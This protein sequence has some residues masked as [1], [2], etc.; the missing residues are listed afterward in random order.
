LL[1]PCQGKPSEKKTRG[2]GKRIY[3]CVPSYALKLLHLNLTKENPVKKT[4][5]KEKEY[6]QYNHFT[7]PH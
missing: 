1:K 5:V 7:P 2:E 3:S 4:L 6:S